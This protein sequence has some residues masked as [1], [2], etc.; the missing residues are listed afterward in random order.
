MLEGGA[1]MNVQR[2]LDILREIKDVAFAT[3]DE[4]GFPQIR[5]IDVM[6]VENEKL[7]FCTARGKDFYH[8]IITNGQVSI[9][10]MNKEFQMVRLN[11]KA[12]K[13][14]ENRK[15]IDRIFEENPS[16]N[17]VYPDES[18]YVLE[19]FCIE[20]GDVEFFDLGKEPIVRESFTL[21]NTMAKEAGFLI[22]DSC[23]HCGKCERICPQKCI[24]DCKINQKHCLHCGLCA[25]ECPVNAIIKRGK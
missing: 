5:I 10:G 16:M 8:Q 1:Y 20:K 2:C 22:T 4:N 9:T 24:I 23:I 6:I 18:R 7:Y 15:W 14:E 11:G 25:E 21:G 3:V 12:E 19:A 13:L 17:A